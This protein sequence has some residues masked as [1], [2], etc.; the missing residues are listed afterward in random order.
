MRAGAII[1]GLCAALAATGCVE[2]KLTVVSN[3]PGARVYLDGQEMGITPV[4]F[5]FD[6]YGKREFMLRKDGYRTLRDVRD[7]NEP[8]YEKPVVNVI[9]DLTPLPFSDHKTVEFTLEPVREVDRDSLLDRANEM[10]YRLEGKPIP[11]RARPSE[12]ESEATPAPET[13]APETPPAPAEPPAPE[14]A[15]ETPEPL[16]P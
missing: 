13:P 5:R 9:S 8:F 12:P 15:P 1:L 16:T 14:P 7:V 10:K 2:R 4:T 6:W 11:A 3:P